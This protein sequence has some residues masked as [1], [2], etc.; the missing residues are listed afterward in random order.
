MYESN[1][2]V[3]FAANAA[4]SKLD[5]EGFLSHCTEDVRWTMVGDETIEG[6]EAVRR[7]M[8]A[9]YVEAPDFDARTLIAEGDLLAVLG[10]ISVKT[11]GGA[12]VRSSYCDVWRFRGGRMA[13][14]KAYVVESK[15][16]S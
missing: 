4:I 2:A 14:L 10:E 16:R 12:T 9:T 3:L 11:P 1:K 8:E 7:W 6:K 5:I 13:E 15:D